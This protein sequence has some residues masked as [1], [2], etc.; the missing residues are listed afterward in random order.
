MLIQVYRCAGSARGRC[1]P[2]VSGT[3]PL[4]SLPGPPV[5]L[6]N[7]HRPSLS[8]VCVSESPPQ[9]WLFPAN[10]RCRAVN[11]KDREFVVG[12]FGSA[13]V[14]KVEVTLWRAAPLSSNLIHPTLVALGFAFNNARITL[15]VVRNP[16]VVV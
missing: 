4:S 5:A 1:R 14:A 13:N 12:L 2:C 11:R 9:Y 10:P 6:P 15:L 3:A 8:E 16:L 7:W